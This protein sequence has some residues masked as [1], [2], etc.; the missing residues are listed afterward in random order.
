MVKS[1]TGYSGWPSKHL[2]EN[3]ASEAEYHLVE[4]MATPGGCIGEQDNR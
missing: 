4:V 2:L 1:Q 3:K